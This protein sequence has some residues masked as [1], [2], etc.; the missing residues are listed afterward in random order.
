MEID[1]M[2]KPYHALRWQNKE[3][4]DTDLFLH[5]CRRTIT[6]SGARL[7]QWLRAGSGTKLLTPVAHLSPQLYD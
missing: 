6:P 5:V 4:E 1:R 7:A 2:E 3:S